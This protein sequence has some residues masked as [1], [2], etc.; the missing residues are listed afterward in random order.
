MLIVGGDAQAVG[1]FAEAKVGRFLG[2]SSKSVK[3]YFDP[4]YGSLIGTFS[5]LPAIKFIP[6]FAR[7]DFLE[8]FTLFCLEILRPP[9][10]AVDFF[11]SFP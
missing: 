11:S 4:V 10:L 5:E 7:I 2:E 8:R 1:R 9:N 3:S 6:L